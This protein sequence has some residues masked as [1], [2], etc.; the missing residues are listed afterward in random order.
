MKR[1]P[2]VRRFAKSMQCMPRT[3]VFGSLGGFRSIDC[4]AHLSLIIERRRP[5]D[6]SSADSSP[7]VSTLRTRFDLVCKSGGRKYLKPWQTHGLEMTGHGSMYI[8]TSAA[9]FQTRSEPPMKA[10]V[11]N[12]Q[13][14][15]SRVV[16]MPTSHA[17]LSYSTLNR[18]RRNRSR[19]PS[20][21][22]I[23]RAYIGHR[24]ISCRHSP[25]VQRVLNWQHQE[26]EYIIH[27]GYQISHGQH[28][29]QSKADALR[30]G[31]KVVACV[32]SVD[33]DER[34]YCPSVAAW[35]FDRRGPR[36]EGVCV[37]TEPVKCVLV[38][39]SAAIPVC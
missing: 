26:V 14:A 1:Q 4:C 21:E 25:A 15:K 5:R 37:F 38:A 7:M 28:F 3:Q 30:W 9:A 33:C 13:G 31:A 36:S 39:D 18:A 12:Y 17:C 24:V 10:E 20:V 6:E 27:H 29:C 22:R 32:R 11:A 19:G 16:T 35:G 23:P 2:E 8:Q 34:V